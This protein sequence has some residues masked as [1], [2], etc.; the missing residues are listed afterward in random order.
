V[1]FSIVMWVTFREDQPLN[2]VQGCFYLMMTNPAFHAGLFLIYPSIRRGIICFHPK[3][4]GYDYFI[5][6]YLYKMFKI[7]P[8]K[9]NLNMII[10]LATLSLLPAGRRPT[11]PK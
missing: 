1:H 10:Y 4:P 8:A 7:L 5:C 11:T 6:T 9:L 3:S 2:F